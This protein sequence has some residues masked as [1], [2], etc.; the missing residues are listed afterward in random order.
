MDIEWFSDEGEVGP[1]PEPKG[2]ACPY[3]TCVYGED[4]CPSALSKP[5]DIEDIDIDDEVSHTESFQTLRYGLKPRLEQ[6][7]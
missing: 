6:A 7:V 5:N 2:L 1:I 4:W 3:A